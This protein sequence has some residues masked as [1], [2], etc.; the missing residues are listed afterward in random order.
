[1]GRHHF[2][3]MLGLAGLFVLRVLA[4]LIQAVSPVSF[5]PPFQDWHGAVMPYPLLLAFQVGI[6]LVLAIVVRRV[7]TG[8]IVPAAW[9]ST[10]LC[11]ASICSISVEPD[12]GM[13]TM[14]IGVTSDAVP[15]D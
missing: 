7:W 13:P 11:V 1:M 15:A 4:Q 14:N 5:L 3:W 10:W 6:V 2:A 12:L 8:A 9:L